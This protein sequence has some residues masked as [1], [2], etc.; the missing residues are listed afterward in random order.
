MVYQWRLTVNKD[1]TK[2][3]RKQQQPRSQYVF[4]YGIDIQ[5][6]I[7]KYK[8]LA[9]A[10]VLAGGGGRALGAVFS[11]FSNLRYIGYTAFSKLFQT[12]VSP[13]LEY[14]SEVWDYKAYIKCECVRQRE[15]RSYLGVHPQTSIIAL[16]RDMGWSSTKLLRHTKMTKY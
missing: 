6:K 16:N 14:A 13:I 12:S 3:F 1:K 10:H 5:E 7:D 15:A 9:K 11:K 4:K 2:V 8:Y